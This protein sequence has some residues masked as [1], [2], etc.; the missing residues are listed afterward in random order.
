MQNNHKTSG[1][2]N[3]SSN[4]CLMV[5]FSGTTLVSRYQTVTWV[6]LELRM[7]DVMVTTGAKGDGCD[8]D[9]WS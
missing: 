5:V 8:G 1:N 7:M 3:N 9:K 4:S 6:L 2:C